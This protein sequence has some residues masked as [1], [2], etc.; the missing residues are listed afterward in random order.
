MR[1]WFFGISF[2]L[3][4]SSQVALS[5]SSSGGHSSSSDLIDEV[6][7]ETKDVRAYDWRRDQLGLEYSRFTVNE[8]NNFESQ[9]YSVGLRTSLS[10]RL[11]GVLGFRFIEVKPTNSSEM[12]ALTPYQQAAQTNRKEIYMMGYYPL[13]AGRSF[14]LLSPWIADWEHT[15]Y[16]KMGIH[17]NLLGRD[18]NFSST[19]PQPLPGQRAITYKWVGD[20]GFRL[21]FSLPYSFSLFFDV[22]NFFPLKNRD[23]DLPQWSNM[24]GGIA[25]SFY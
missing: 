2:L 11:M 9:G 20:I 18:L 14:T 22:D 15:V 8:K 13:I 3:C 10:P 25:W 23:G 6:I 4:F 24:G 19:E 5:A 16:I 1:S 12:I 21:Q 7:S 17:Y